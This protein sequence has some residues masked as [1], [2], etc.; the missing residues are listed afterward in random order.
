MPEPKVSVIIPVYNG[1]KTLESCLNSVL[2]Q[3]YQ[4][5]EVVVVDNNSTDRSKEIIQKYKNIKYVFE[6]KL[7][8]GAARNAG[9]RAS[10][11]NI[12]ACTDCDCTFPRD[13]LEILTFPIREEGEQAVQGFQK[14]AVNNFWSRNIQK[15]DW[16]FMKRVMVGKYIN[17]VDTKN[18]AIK[19]DILKKLMFDPDIKTL[20]DLDLYLRLKKVSKIRFLPKCKVSHLHKSS[21]YEVSRLN[22]DRGYWTNK[23]RRKN[24]KLTNEPM[25]ESISL[26]NF[27]FFPFWITLQLFNMP[28]RDFFFILVSELSWRTGIIYAIL[29]PSA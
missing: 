11:G 3:I 29:N 5:Y 15:A 20:D 7:G 10:S 2:T 21:F 23:I 22:F 8:R 4:N 13:W 9:I 1:E 17:H 12:I 14:E 16:E 25:F 19:A 6:A 27:I 28:I 24:K 26:K 18:F